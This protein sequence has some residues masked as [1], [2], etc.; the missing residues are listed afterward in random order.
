M[1]A[2]EESCPGSITSIVDSVF[3]E[4]LSKKLEKDS[5]PKKSKKDKH[6]K[7]KSDSEKREKIKTAPGTV[8]N[9]K[10]HVRNYSPDTK[11]E[12]IRHRHGPRSRSPRR[13]NR[14]AEVKTET[15]FFAKEG[16]LKPK[17]KK[18]KKS[19]KHK[20]DKSSR[21]K[22]HK[23]DKP[24]KNLSFDV[25]FDE[26][27]SDSSE[28]SEKNPETDI[29]VQEAT[30]KLNSMKSKLNKKHKQ[31]ENIHSSED[32]SRLEKQIKLRTEIS[33][34]DKYGDK[35]E[36][37]QLISL[38][39]KRRSKQN[40]SSEPENKMDNGQSSQQREKA[41]ETGTSV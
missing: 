14:Q 30:S 19:K 27:F 24:D 21:K 3:S 31:L 2:V 37:D 12:S 40:D 35:N 6:K 1:S 7:R 39:T 13:E 4:F 5:K 29:L 10:K 25:K 36:V 11:F 28:D 20:K 23:R 41:D 26:A 8:I 34:V 18:D 22:S 9:L 38:N 33:L 17:S 15:S 16:F 32:T